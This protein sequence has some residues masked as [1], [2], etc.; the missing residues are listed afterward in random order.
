MYHGSA[1]SRVPTWRDLHVPAL[2]IILGSAACDH[3]LEARCKR[4][5]GTACGELGDREHDLPE[6]KRDRAR[7]CRLYGRACD[8]GNVAGC[9]NLGRLM[10]DATCAGTP[11]EGLELSRRACERG[12]AEA[13][14]NV[15]EMLRKGRPGVPVDLAQA[16]IVLESAC[17]D[18]PSACTNLG[19]HFM[20]L[21]DEAKANGAFKR[22]CEFAG[23]GAMTAKG[24]FNLAVSYERGIG[25]PA[26]RS[27]AARLYA[28][29]C[30]RSLAHGCYSIGHIEL[31]SDDPRGKERAAAHFR[32]ACEG[33]VA[34]AC[35]DL[36]VMHA[37]GIGV[38]R[39]LNRAIEY[40][41]KGCAGGALA[42][43]A[44]LGKRYLSGE[45]VAKDPAKGRELIHRACAG[46]FT[47]A[48]DLDTP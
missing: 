5:D 29:A 28:L 13:C 7:M 10:M 44:N 15:G 37:D 21:K 32:Q 25:L 35:N 34:G 40:F 31:D 26:D 2:L 19:V 42:A 24:C 22:S 6:G 14:N 30:E 18:L 4:G 48:C 17:R 39:D 1:M 36:G 33:S 46:G 3:S 27:E 8:K 23:G 41:E 47:A 12:A 11:K 16:T 20:T 45:G 9:T 43:C 38:A